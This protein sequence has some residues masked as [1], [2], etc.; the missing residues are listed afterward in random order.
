MQTVTVTILLVTT[1]EASNS[2]AGLAPKSRANVSSRTAEDPMYTVEKAGLSHRAQ[3]QREP[4]RQV[5]T[6]L[7]EDGIQLSPDKRQGEEL[8]FDPNPFFCDV[9]AA[10]TAA[11]ATFN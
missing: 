1:P 2:A 4:V 6:R 3:H 9:K 5:P 8:T 10:H 7:D 11:S